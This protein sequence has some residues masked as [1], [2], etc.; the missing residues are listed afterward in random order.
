M[1]KSNSQTDKQT[2]RDRH[3]EAVLRGVRVKIEN[4]GDRET[5]RYKYN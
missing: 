1:R 4:E 5:D 2:D 3:R